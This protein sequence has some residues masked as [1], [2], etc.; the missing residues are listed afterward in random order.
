M[1]L[2]SLL[3]YLFATILIFIPLYPKFP[4]FMLP[5]STVAVRTE[6]FLLFITFGLT[7]VSYILSKKKIVPPLALQIFTFFCVG[8]IS[9]ISAI[10]VTKTA[11]AN[12]AILHWLRRIEYI[13]VF[14]IAWYIGKSSS[15]NRRFFFELILLP[16]IGVFLYGLAQIFLHAP[17][18][19]TMNA[20]FSKGIA[21]TLQPGVQLS[22]TF[23]GHYDLAIYLVMIMAFLSSV[24]CVFESKKVRIP[25]LIGLVALLWLFMQAGSR[26]SLF[27]IF[28]V[29]WYVAW[30][31]KKPIWGIILSVA[32]FTSIL[33]SPN[34]MN[35]LLNIIKIIPIK[36]ETQ[37]IRPVFAADK[38]DRQIQQDRS[39]SIRIDV[40]WPRAM[41]SFY[42]NPFLGTGYSSLGLAT[43][44]DYL[45]SIGE[46]GLLGLLSFLAMLIALAKKLFLIKPKNSIDKLILISGQAV[47]IAF[48]TTGL[49]LDVFESSKIAIMFWAISGLSLSVK[50]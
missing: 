50:S 38:I 22:S 42:K 37:V 15:S 14:F 6:D 2:N 3:K 48:I 5:G 25:A 28:L 33:T 27:S 8:A 43:D 24:I 23:G 32:V 29:V 17:V 13:S 10:F 20:E 39:T 9:V 16:A 11:S 26:I 45:R 36:I 49:F 35:R 34:L 4:L 21:L 18:I 44:N 41:R 1:F 30:A 46:T 19:S 31:Y 47:F 40:E 12:I 7:V